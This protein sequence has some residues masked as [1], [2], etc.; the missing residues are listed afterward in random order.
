MG[1]VV[2]P[3]LRAVVPSGR[4][5][6]ARSWPR[7]HTQAPGHSA[8]S[9]GYTSTLSGT[10][11][12]LGDPRDNCPEKVPSSGWL[13]FWAA[14]AERERVSIALRQWTFLLSECRLCGL[15]M[16]IHYSCKTFMYLKGT[17][18]EREGNRGMGFPSIRYIPPNHCNDQEAKPLQSRRQ[19][20]GT[21]S[22]S[23]TVGDRVEALGPSSAVSPGALAGSRN[24]SGTTR[25]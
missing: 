14:W 16:D 12:S 4:V 10:A 3:P 15:K 20:P 17:V 2:E 22:G 23:P 21:P 18:A 13:C 9:L 1:T 19:E 7:T 6:I 11:G 8:A 24:G 25:T 5:R